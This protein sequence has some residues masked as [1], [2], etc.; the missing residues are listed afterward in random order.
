[1]TAPSAGLTD[2]VISNNRAVG[3]D[4]QKRMKRA[5]RRSNYRSGTISQQAGFFNR[6]VISGNTIQGKGAGRGQRHGVRIGTDENEQNVIHN[7]AFGRTAG[8]NIH[9]EDTANGA[10]LTDNQFASGRKKD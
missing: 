6:N 5:K 4:S 1:M 8:S 7:N 10:V 2:S 9:F 3:E